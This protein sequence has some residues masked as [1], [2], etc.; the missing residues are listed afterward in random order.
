VVFV[1]W[2]WVIPVVALIVW[3]LSQVSR[4]GQANPPQPPPRPAPRKGRSST[5]EI[6]RFLEE[7]NRRREQQ[8]QQQQARREVVEA[9]LVEEV[10]EVRRERP[11]PPPRQRPTAPP[12]RRKPAVPTVEAVPVPPP[13]PPIPAPAPVPEVPALLPPT[14]PPTEEV[15]SLEFRPIAPVPQRQPSPT[16]VRLREMLTAQGIRTA[17]LVNELLARPKCLRRPFR[18]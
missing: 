4:A 14:L 13:P 12:P 18:R 6:D 16:L 2:A 15:G 1:D 7:I 5:E 8:K 17:I 9:V 3:I 10:P 11:K